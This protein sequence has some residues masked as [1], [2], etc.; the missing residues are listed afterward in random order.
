MDGDHQVTQLLL[1]MQGGDKDAAEALVPLV[2]AQ[3]RR[4]A[5]RYLRQ[6][7]PG[8]TLQPTALVN[9]AFL[10]LIPAGS[11]DWQGREHFLA[12]AARCMRMLLVDH[13]RRS[14]ALK[15]GGGSK[16]VSLDS[17]V[18]SIED[19]F[20]ELIELEEALENLAS[21][22][23]RAARVVELRFFAGLTAPEAARVMETSLRTVEREWTVARAWL[24]DQLEQAEGEALEE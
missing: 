5:D 1:A 3:M 21:L 18:V 14:K 23:P 8:H 4:L 10:K 22:S 7:G 24:L 17:V 2:Q 12:V 9:E 16:H 19:R 11:V 15:R 13:A 6:E 20:I